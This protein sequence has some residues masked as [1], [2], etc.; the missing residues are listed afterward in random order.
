MHSSFC[1]LSVLGC[2]LHTCTVFDIYALQ[3]YV[4]LCVHSIEQLTLLF[5]EME[6]W[7]SVL[8]Q[9]MAEQPCTTQCLILLALEV[10]H[11]PCTTQMLYVFLILLLYI[12]THTQLFN[13][14]LSGLH[15]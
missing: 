9:K 3:S 5:P 12:H 14:F 2:C 4:N 7:K 1:T 10:W 8:H 11:W 15:R 6:N 13:S